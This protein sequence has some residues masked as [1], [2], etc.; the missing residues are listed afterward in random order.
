HHESRLAFRRGSTARPT[1]RPPHR[2]HQPDGTPPAYFPEPRC[3][4]RGEPPREESFAGHDVTAIPEPVAKRSYRHR[5]QNESQ[6]RHQT[7]PPRRIQVTPTVIDHVSPGRSGRPNA[8]AKKTETAFQQHNPAEIEG[9]K[10]HD[11]GHQ[12]RKQMPGH[13]AEPVRPQGHRT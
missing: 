12:R 11:R 9:E 5:Q 8:D 10:Y 1:P 7:D 3:W 4:P 2:V 6:A 13:D